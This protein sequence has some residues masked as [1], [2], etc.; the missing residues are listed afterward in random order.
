MC[1]GILPSQY[2]HFITH[3]NLA[4]DQVQYVIHGILIKVTS[5]FKKG[6]YLEAIDT[7][8][9]YESCEGAARVCYK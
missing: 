7:C 5:T 2:I 9:N 4:S 6:G 1:V 8:A 3:A